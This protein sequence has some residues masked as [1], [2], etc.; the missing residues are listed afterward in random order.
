MAFFCVAAVADS[1]LILVAAIR[2]KILR[3]QHGSEIS[4][5]RPEVP[6]KNNENFQNF[7]NFKLCFKI[8][9]T[10][11]LGVSGVNGDEK[12]KFPVFKLCPAGL[13][14]YTGF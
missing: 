12:F 13:P 8:N 4:N 6:E 2:L 9:K 11:S 3:G 1:G 10:G 5:F 7:E 14:V